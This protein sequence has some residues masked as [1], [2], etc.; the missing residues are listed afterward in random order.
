MASPWSKPL[1]LLCLVASGADAQNWTNYRGNVF[2]CIEG[3]GQRICGDVVPRSCAG[4][5]YSIYSGKTG[6]LLRTI[7]PPPS[8]EEKERESQEKIRENRESQAQLESKRRRSAILVTYGSLA[9]LD[10][11]QAETENPLKKDIA[12][13]QE[14][15]DEAQK[16]LDVSRETA[17]RYTKE[18]VPPELA[19]SMHDSEMEV[20]FQSELIKMKQL[21][22]DK[23]RKKFEEDRKL[24][25]EATGK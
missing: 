9:E 16:R 7:D 23:A 24:Y 3:S 19:A 14:R 22:L 6:L 18:Q 10:R 5:A 4:R 8:R 25:R 20:K 2:C 21:E 13:A 11:V 15:I 12:D 1:L 17:K